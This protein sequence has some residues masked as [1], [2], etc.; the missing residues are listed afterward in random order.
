MATIAMKLKG[1][2]YTTVMNLPYSLANKIRISAL[3]VLILTFV[4][5][6]SGEN[7]YEDNTYEFLKREYS[8]TKPYQGKC[9]P[10]RSLTLR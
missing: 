10:I 8:L 2:V 9:I 5:S 3:L 1:A 7:T 6:S 4:S